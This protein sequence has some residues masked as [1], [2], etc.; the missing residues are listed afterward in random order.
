MI[1]PYRI[2]FNKADKKIKLILLGK[3]Y[4]N[5]INDNI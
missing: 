1:S 2:K 5:N 3:I 4:K